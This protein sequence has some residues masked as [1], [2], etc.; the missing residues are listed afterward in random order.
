MEDMPVFS[1]SCG[2]IYHNNVV[3]AFDN[4][5]KNIVVQKITAV[6]FTG[7]ATPKSVM[8]MFLPLL[9]TF[10]IYLERNMHGLLRLA[11]V[12]VMLAVFGLAFYYAEKQYR[13]SIVMNDGSK[14]TIR[15]SKDNRKE[16]RK[17]VDK[18][19]ANIGL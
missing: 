6:K 4:G 18:L 7:R 10:L 16:A 19:R 15:V 9:A 5:E 11:G 3:F 1:N 8:I 12:G 2:K 14:T 17:F 13:I